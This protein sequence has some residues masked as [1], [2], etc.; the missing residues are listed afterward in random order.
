M[1]AAQKISC[2]TEKDAE[3]NIVPNHCQS[4]IHLEDKQYGINGNYICDV[5]VINCTLADNKMDFL[6][7]FWGGDQPQ[8]FTGADLFVYNSIVLFKRSNMKQNARQ[9]AILDIITKNEV[10]TQGELTDLL[11][12]EGFDATQATVS[13]D[14]NELGLIKTTGSIKKF[15]YALKKQDEQIIKMSKIFKE[16]VISFDTAM[17]LLVL[18]TFAGSAN[19]AAAMIDR[20]NIPQIVATIA[21]D[22]TI[23]VITKSVEDVQ[24]VLKA[25][26]EYL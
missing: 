4:L 8:G 17:N 22:D 20:L 21:G 12:K 16:S 24:K 3:G 14:I 2:T 1:I 11:R 6:N 9:Q 7:V 5:N 26:K 13:R 23:M 25:L 18:K 15:R 10:S 19:A